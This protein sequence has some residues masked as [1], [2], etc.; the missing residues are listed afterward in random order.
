MWNKLSV[1]QRVLL[2]TSSALILAQVV[3]LLVGGPF[4]AGMVIAAGVLALVAVAVS[5]GRRAD[6]KA[7]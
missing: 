4:I 6:R 5:M 1:A 3:I 2:L 7:P